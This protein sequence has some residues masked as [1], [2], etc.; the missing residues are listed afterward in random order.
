MY[1]ECVFVR[2]C[3]EASKYFKYSNKT[4][5]VFVTKTMLVDMLPYLTP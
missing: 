3:V 4:L 5:V 1:D 2:A